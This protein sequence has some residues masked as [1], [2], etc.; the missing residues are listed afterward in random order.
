MSL[1]RAQM[2]ICRI[3][4]R[5]IRLLALLEIPTLSYRQDIVIDVK[6]SKGS[7]LSFRGLGSLSVFST[8]H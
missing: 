5:E 8:R 7:L 4:F 1:I 6:I 2:R 3:D